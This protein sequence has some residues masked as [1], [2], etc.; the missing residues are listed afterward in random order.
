MAV[1]ALQHP[2]PLM[3]TPSDMERQAVRDLTFG[4]RNLRDITAGGHALAQ[5]VDSAWGIRLALDLA[6]LGDTSYMGGF[7]YLISVREPRACMVVDAN[8]CRTSLKGFAFS[9][10]LDGLTPWLNNLDPLVAMALE[11][12]IDD[13]IALL[14]VWCEPRLPANIQGEE[15]W[16]LREDLSDGQL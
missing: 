7:E 13:Q 1:S 4:I 6:D 10:G 14:Y 15:A 3:A 8:L 12:T 9:R 11:I 16:L 5:G 2:Q